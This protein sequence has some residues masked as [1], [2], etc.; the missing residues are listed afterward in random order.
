MK[1]F[2]TKLL[3]RYKPDSQV[4]RT[5]GKKPNLP[6]TNLLLP[7]V[8]ESTLDSLSNLRRAERT[9]QRDNSELRTDTNSETGRRETHQTQ[10]I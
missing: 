2:T 9:E 5:S 1:S 6:L 10:D 7:L 4:N 3:K 8:S